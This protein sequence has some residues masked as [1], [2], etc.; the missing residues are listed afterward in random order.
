MAIQVRRG[1]YGDFD[2]N[3]LVPGEPATVLGND[4]FAT[5]GR[6]VYFCLAAGVVK[7]L[8]TYEDWRDE[9]DMVKDETV[10]WIVNTAN[11]DFKEEYAEV[12]DDAKKAE[13]ERRSNESSRVAAEEKRHAAENARIAAE[14]KRESAEAER[15]VTIREFERQVAAGDFN[16]ATFTPTVNEAGVLSWTN[17]KGLQNPLAVD[18]RGP[19]GA[20]GVVTQLAAGMYALQIEGDDLFLVY[21]DDAQAP[22]LAIEEDGHL[23]LSVEG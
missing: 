11:A 21:G 18:V 2:P 17:D 6:A 23:W 5:D 22:D 4:P 13:D 12:R 16:G 10:D 1:L 9:F 8:V 7:R 20:D 3:S 14:K 15:V 19:K